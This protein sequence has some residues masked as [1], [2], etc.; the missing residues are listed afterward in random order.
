MKIQKSIMA[1]FVFVLLSWLL[2]SACW[3]H[4]TDKVMLLL[5]F[6]NFSRKQ[7]TKNLIFVTV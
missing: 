2:G 4:V 6:H 1:C 5:Q 7:I 3:E